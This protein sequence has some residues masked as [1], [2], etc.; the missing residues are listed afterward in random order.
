[1]ALE[2]FNAKH[3]ARTSIKATFVVKLCRSAK[4]VSELWSMISTGFNGNS[5]TTKPMFNVCLKCFGLRL[6]RV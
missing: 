3:T 2:H 1:M 5:Q 4:K 6:A